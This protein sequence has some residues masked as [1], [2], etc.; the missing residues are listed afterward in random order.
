M[1]TIFMES[2]TDATQG[3][4]FYS[5]VTNPTKVSSDSTIK[6]T[7][8]RSIKCTGGSPSSQAYVTKVS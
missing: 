3:F 5:S 1:A 2:G 8:P 6:L 7:G 4:E